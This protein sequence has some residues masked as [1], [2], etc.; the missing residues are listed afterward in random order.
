MP[1]S[2]RN[3][4]EDYNKGNTYNI[5]NYYLKSSEF[6]K[7]ILDLRRE[8]FLGKWKKWFSADTKLNIP[9]LYD[10]CINE[11]NRLK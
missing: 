8:L 11:Y 10:F 2:K 3:A 1:R 4:I 6:V 7:N 5:S 9:M